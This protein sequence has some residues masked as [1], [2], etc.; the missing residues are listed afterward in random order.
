MLAGCGSSGP[1][2]VRSEKE[3]GEPIVRV[4]IER[5]IQQIRFTGPSRV[6]IHAAKAGS[7]GA[8]S[9]GSDRDPGRLF[10]TPVTI[11]RSGGRWT[12]PWSGGAPGGDRTLVIEPLGSAPLEIG[13][14]G[15]RYPGA[16]RLVPVASKDEGADRTE[17]GGRGGGRGGATRFDAVNHLRLEAYLP[18]VLDRELYSHWRP[19]TYLAQAIVARS[20]AIDRMSAGAGGRHFDMENTQASQAYSGAS[21]NELAVRAVADTMGLVLTDGRRV[22]P[23]YY[24]STCGGIGQSPADAFGGDERVPRPLEPGPERTW[25]SISK[26]YRWGPIERDRA[27]LSKRIR[28][29]GEHHGVAIAQLGEIRGVTISRRNEPGRPV[30]FDVLDDRGKRYRLRA[31]SL[32]HACNHKPDD[33]DGEREIALPEITSSNRVR[34]GFF[35]G[36]VEEGTIVFR[37]GRGFGH[38]VGLCQYGTEGMARAG[39]DV[40]SI[41]EK[42]YPGASLERAY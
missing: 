29:W 25:C 41:L 8:A 17:A 22:L 10:S 31:D 6:Q 23:A 7:D 24:S 12:G 30:R 19:A 34:S 2:P 42:F 27:D 26:Y 16:V 28:L 21:G 5:A 37:D 3:P 35:R 9:A 1:P 15:L 14:G 32:R 33:K 4:R 18:G 39:R 13:E 36:E 40:Q 38:G 11:H 20:Y